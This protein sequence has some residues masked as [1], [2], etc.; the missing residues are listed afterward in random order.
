[1]NAI[2][3]RLGVRVVPLSRRQRVGVALGYVAGAALLY[4][5]DSSASPFALHVARPIRGAAIFQAIVTGIEILAGWV[6][7]AAEVTAAYVWIALQWLGT[8]TATFL[9]NTGAMFAKVWDGVKVVWSDVL[10]P[11]LMWVDDKLKSLYAWLQDTF[12]PVFNFLREVRCRLNDF[13]TTFVRPVVDTIEFIRQINRVLLAFHISLLQGSTRRCSRSN[14]ASKSRS[15]GS[16]P[17]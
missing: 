8:A 7:T 13:Y 10:K 4:W 12:K 14:S 6:A 3:R 16:T 15:C 5:L 2:T 11:A 9:R 17:S 1:M